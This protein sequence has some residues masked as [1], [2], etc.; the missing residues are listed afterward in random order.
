MTNENYT[1]VMDAVATQV[2]PVKGLAYQKRYMRCFMRKPSNMKIHEFVAHVNELN[3]YLKQFP[4]K[5][6]NQELQPDE[7]KDIFEFVIPNKWYNQVIV[8]G[9]DIMSMTNNKFIEFCE[10]ME[11]IESKSRRR[12]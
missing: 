10:H 11:L 2:L 9:K 1:K 12:P 3:N 4:P 6:E 7:L 5:A 8:Q